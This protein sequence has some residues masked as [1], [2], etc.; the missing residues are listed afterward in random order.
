MATAFYQ[1][2]LEV[3]Q[4]DLQFYESMAQS[5][6][7][8]TWKNWNRT[9]DITYDSPDNVMRAY[10]RTNLFAF[11]G[12]KTLVEMQELSQL[13]TDD[14][15]DPLPFDK[16]KE[17]AKSIHET[18][19]VNYLRAEYNAAVASSQ[20]ASNWISYE[21]AKDEYPY[22]RYD[23]AGDERVRQSHAALDGKI[24]PIDDPSWDTIFPPNGW[25]CRC[26]V[27]QVHS[28]Y[29]GKVYNSNKLSGAIKKVVSETPSI[30]RQNPGKTGI[31]FTEHHPYFKDYNQN[32]LEATTNYGMQEIE[33]IKKK[34]QSIGELADDVTINKEWNLLV[35]KYAHNDGISFQNKLGDMIYANKAVVSNQLIQYFESLLKNPDEV[36]SRDGISYFLKFYKNSLHAAVLNE[37]LEVTGYASFEEK[38]FKEF[39]KG[40]LLLRR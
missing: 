8:E 5:L 16:F 24:I 11:S 10:F 31:I 36:W 30:F 12:A 21:E 40:T 38:D 23:T 39:R 22:L 25:N 18:Y 26:D 17:L 27:T 29:K 1:K 9:E 32:E 19:N 6:F 14:N 34:A 20:M 37:N 35:K 2:K 3:G 7:D 28:S 13:L 33:K 15:G 4:I